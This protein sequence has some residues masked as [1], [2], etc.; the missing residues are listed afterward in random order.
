MPSSP[1]RLTV[2]PCTLWSLYFTACYK[3]LIF[4]VQVLTQFNL[5]KC[6]NSHLSEFN[7]HLAFLGPLPQFILIL[8]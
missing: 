5:T 3:A 1:S 6:N 8:L 2:S 7:N 4:I